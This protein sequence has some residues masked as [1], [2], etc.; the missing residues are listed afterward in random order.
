MNQTDQT[1]Q[2]D[3]V[4][5]LTQEHIDQSTP[6][7][8]SCC[9][10]ANLSAQNGFMFPRVGKSQSQVSTYRKV[11]GPYEKC[12]RARGAQKITL[13][14]SPRIQDW[15]INYDAERSKPRT[16]PALNLLLNLNSRTIRT[17]EESSFIPGPTMQTA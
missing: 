10:I 11:P 3:Q 15:L 4:L 16:S 13:H 1:N 8:E 12:S 14:H 9:P 2:A 7:S 6:G 5:R 17:Q